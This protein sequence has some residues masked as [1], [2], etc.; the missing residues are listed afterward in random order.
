[1]SFKEKI[2][3]LDELFAL[4]YLFSP[5]VSGIVV[6]FGIDSR[7]LWLPLGIFL[8]WTLYIYAYRA[9]YQLQDEEERSLIERAR[10]LCYFFGMVVS[11]AINS[12]I[13]FTSLR[14]EHKL[15]IGILAVVL[16]ILIE[17][18]LP[19]AFFEK[20]VR[21]FTKDQ[22][23]MLWR[24]LFHANS[25]A[26]YFSNVVLTFDLLIPQLSSWTAKPFAELMSGLMLVFVVAIGVSSLFAFLAYRQERE[27]RRLA[28]NLAVS[29][30]STKWLKH[31]LEKKTIKKHGVH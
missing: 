16:L 14:F 9:K 8:L 27:S 17:E 20:Q 10:G 22:K 4:L 28:Q 29:L 23:T 21:L 25:V 11:L 6:S 13:F 18:I 2:K 12:V 3:P 19:K 26:L 7:L 30:K 5:I 1:L 15:I 24:S 31:Y